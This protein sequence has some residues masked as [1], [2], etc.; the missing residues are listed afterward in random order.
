[1]IREMM[2][3][4]MNDIEAIFVERKSYFLS[5]AYKILQDRDHAEDAVSEGFLQ[6]ILCRHS[7]KQESPL[8]NWIAGI[9]KYVSFLMRRRG[10]PS[11]LDDQIPETVDPSPSPLDCLIAREQEEAREKVVTLLSPRQREWALGP[12]GT[13]N[14]REYKTAWARRQRVIKQVRRELAVAA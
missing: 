12:L 10:G 5:I 9:V 2:N 11:Q 1:M 4:M 8:V 14:T 3:E 6:A 13:P 7:W